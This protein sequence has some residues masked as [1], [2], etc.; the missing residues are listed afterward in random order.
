MECC[1][2]GSAVVM[3]GILPISKNIQIAFLFSSEVKFGGGC[4]RG[5]MIWSINDLTENTFLVN[6]L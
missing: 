6:M 3:Y 4:G 1:A 5:Q 2:S